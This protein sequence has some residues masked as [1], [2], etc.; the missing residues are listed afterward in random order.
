MA[1]Q[2]PS[3]D[4][5]AKGFAIRLSGQQRFMVHAFYPWLQSQGVTDAETDEALSLIA[6][7]EVPQDEL[8]EAR[9]TGTVTSM[10][11]TSGFRR[12]RVLRVRSE[13]I[14]AVSRLFRLIGAVCVGGQVGSTLIK[15]AEDLESVNLLDQLYDAQRT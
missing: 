1:K 8:R 2:P 5:R 14:Q 4:K 13:H 6:P 3:L 7:V 9:L 10:S 11:Y 12:S 15:R